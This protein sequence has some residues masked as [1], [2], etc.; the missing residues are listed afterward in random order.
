MRPLATYCRIGQFWLLLAVVTVASLY[1]LPQGSLHGG[2]DKILHLLTY[3]FLFISLD[4][5]LTPGRRLLAKFTLLLFCSWLIEVA[6]Y[7]LPAR[8]YSMADLLA[9]FIGLVLGL[10][11]VLLLKKMR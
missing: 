9:N 2:T 5:A 6:Q 1:P 4:F 3:L 11:V 8:K 10:G 7:Y